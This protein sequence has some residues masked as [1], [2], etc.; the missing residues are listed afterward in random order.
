[1]VAR[2]LPQARAT[3]GAFV[4]TWYFEVAVVHLGASGHVRLG[5]STR[6]A[7]LQAPV[8]YD[9]FSYGYRDLEGSKVG[10]CQGCLA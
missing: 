9:Q 4:G 5:W 8:G 3:H 6:R 1:V 7:E 2:A 10:G